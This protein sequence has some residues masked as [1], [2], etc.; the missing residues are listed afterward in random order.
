MRAQ[1]NEHYPMH[2]FG[3]ASSNAP[4]WGSIIR[5][6]RDDDDDNDVTLF[7]ERRNHLVFWWESFWWERDTSLCGFG[8]L[9]SKMQSVT[10]STT[11]A[12]PSYHLQRFAPVVT[13]TSKS[14]HTP[15]FQRHPPFLKG[16]HAT[17][18]TY[19]VVEECGV[20]LEN[21]DSCDQGRLA[22]CHSVCRLT[23][24][25]EFITA[26]RFRAT[27]NSRPTM[28]GERPHVT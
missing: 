1:S 10:S 22:S 24:G 2:R 20:L 15:L 28:R 4:I 12:T 25:G 21:K 3:E 11:A 6:P 27:D 19:S 18:I 5:L 17:Y 8:T 7:V 16:E 23:G 26:V 9:V 13:T 14:R